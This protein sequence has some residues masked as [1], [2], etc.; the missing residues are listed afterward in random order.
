MS[1]MDSVFSTGTF[2]EK[3]LTHLLDRLMKAMQVQNK[4]EAANS[5]L[6]EPPSG[7][8]TGTAK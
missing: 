3:D 1:D 8:T 6:K 5:L 7:D 2:S 4:T